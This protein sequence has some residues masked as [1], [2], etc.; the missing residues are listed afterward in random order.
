MW[1]DFEHSIW[2]KLKAFSLHEKESFI[3]AVSGGLDSMVLLQVMQSLKPKAQLIVAHYHHGPS[4]DS[5]LLNYRDNTFKLVEQVCAEKKL[6]FISGKSSEILSSEDSMREKRFTFFAEVQKS[7]PEAILTTAHHKDDLLETWLLKMVRGAGPESLKNFA[8]W[9]Q[10]ILRPLLDFEKKELKQYANSHGVI[11]LDDPSNAQNDYLRNWLRNE[12]LKQLSD[13]I[14]GSLVNLTDSL[15]RLIAEIDSFDENSVINY[16]SPTP[17]KGWVLRHEFLLMG[18]S[19]RLTTLAKLLRGLGQ[20]DFS[21][22]QLEEVVKRLDKNQK[23][24]IFSIAGV[25]WF[26]NAQ[27]IMVELP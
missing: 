22:G 16:D 10:K 4:H 24:L 17:T 13:K 8:F 26:I 12:W 14:P 27:Q 15:G 18:H 3:L 25:N 2:K 7:Y 19:E 20:R 23:D 11:W 9:N 6:I 5:D 1:T 21:Q